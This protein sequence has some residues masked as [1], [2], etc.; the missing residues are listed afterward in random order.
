[1]QN[2]TIRRT[3]AKTRYAD[4]RATTAYAQSCLKGKPGEARKP[5]LPADDRSGT[6]VAKY[7]APKLQP[8]VQ[9]IA[10]QH[11]LVNTMMRDRDRDND[12]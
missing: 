4:K 11:E 2:I 8:E 5:I 6:L 9:D 1:M 7:R 12:G 10:Q 3:S